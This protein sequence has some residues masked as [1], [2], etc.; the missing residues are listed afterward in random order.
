MVEEGKAE[1]KKA[2]RSSRPRRKLARSLLLLLAPSLLSL[3]RPYPAT[4][5]SGFRLSRGKEGEVGEAGKSP[6][7]SNG[8]SQ[9]GVPDDGGGPLPS[10]SR[11]RIPFRSR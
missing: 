1:K 10:L 7:G 5:A 3:D 2:M 9:G 11:R 8:W 6:E 4:A